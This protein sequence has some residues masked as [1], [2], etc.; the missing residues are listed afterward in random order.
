[1]SFNVQ[2]VTC[3]QQRTGQ[4]RIDRAV[5]IK[6]NFVIYIALFSIQ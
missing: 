1:M 5:E 3:F 4:N 6:T 2:D